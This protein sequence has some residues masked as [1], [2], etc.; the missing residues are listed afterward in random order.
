MSTVKS[1]LCTLHTDIAQ[2]GS[3]LDVQAAQ[4][5][6]FQINQ[7]FKSDITFIESELALKILFA[8]D[9]GI[10]CF[11][12]S[13]IS[14][15]PINT[16][17]ITVDILFLFQQLIESFPM[18]IVN[19]IKSI[20]NLCNLSTITYKKNADLSIR[21]YQLYEKLL[22]TKHFSDQIEINKIVEH[23]NN[24]V[25]LGDKI[26][27][28]ARQHIYNLFGVIAQHHPMYLK[29]YE[30]K[31]MN[32]FCYELQS[33]IDIRETN[34]KKFL[35]PV[36]VGCL[37]GLTGFLNNFADHIKTRDYCLRLYE[38][39]KKLIG[40]VE[41]NKRHVINRT[42]LNLFQKHIQLFLKLVFQ[43]STEVMWFQKKLW[44]WSLLPNI[45][46]K[47]IGLS[48]FEIFHKGASIEFSRQN[49]IIESNISNIQQEI[50][51]NMIMFLQ[52]KLCDIKLNYQ[53]HA[54]VVRSIGWLAE[55]CNN[56][57][58]EK[59]LVEIFNIFSLQAEEKYLNCP[60]GKKTYDPNAANYLNSLSLII[61]NIKSL[62]TDQ[63]LF[64]QKLSIYCFNDFISAQSKS[65]W[66]DNISNAIIISI[67][68][69]A[70][71]HGNILDKYLKQL[72][73][74]GLI[75]SC[76]HR[77]AIDAEIVE[78]YTGH[79]LIK[80]TN[81][82]SLW[83]S[84]L[85]AHQCHLF[86][87]YLNI[88]IIVKSTLE[89][90]LMCSF[91]SSVLKIIKKLDLSTNKSSDELEVEYIAR[92]PADI[93]ALVNLVE[94]Y[95]DILHNL[96]LDIESASSWLPYTLNVIINHSIEYPTIS[97]LYRILAVI[98]QELDWRTFLE[99]INNNSIKE[100][101][102]EYVNC[103]MVYAH[104]F[105]GDLQ[106]CCLNMFMCLPSTIV[107]EIFNTQIVEVVKSTLIVGSIFLPMAKS[108]VNALKR[109][110]QDLSKSEMDQLLKCIMPYLDLL[111]R[112][113]GYDNEVE[114]NN[115]VLDQMQV[116]DN[117]KR[118]LLKQDKL[119][120]KPETELEI[121]QIQILEYLSRLDM[122]TCLE[123]LGDPDRLINYPR[124]IINYKL[125][126]NDC[127][128]NISFDHLLPRILELC[129]YC[130]NRQIRFTAC[131]IFHAYIILYLGNN[132]TLERSKP[133][134]MEIVT[135]K[136][137]PI[138]IK[139]ACDMD[140]LIQQLFEPLAI[141][142]VHYFASGIQYNSIY[143][144]IIIDILM[145]SISENSNEAVRDF[146][147]KCIMEF[148]RWTLKDD[149]LSQQL[150]IS[151]RIIIKKIKS[152]CLHP[153]P[154]KQ[155]G[156]AVA[157]NSC[158][159]ILREDETII[160]ELWIQLLYYFIVKLDSTKSTNSEQHILK[161]L[162]HLQRVFLEKSNLFNEIC[163]SRIIPKPF[164]GTQ[165]FN[166]VEWLLRYIGS[167]MTICRS[168]CFDMANSLSKNVKD[169]N[170]LKSI[171]NSFKVSHGEKELINC[172]ERDLTSFKVLTNIDILIHWLNQ[173]IATL[174]CYTSLFKESM[175]DI[176]LLKNP[177][178]CL[179]Q[180]IHQFLFHIEELSLMQWL[181]Y[182][183]TP[184]KKNDKNI[185][186]Q[187]RYF[188]TLKNHV[189][190]G[191][192]QFINVFENNLI[193]GLLDEASQEKI[194]DLAIKYL[195]DCEMVYSD[196]KL[197]LHKLV[198]LQYIK[199]P[200][201][202]NKFNNKL[203][204]HLSKYW[205]EVDFNFN[206][207][208]EYTFK[209]NFIAVNQLI[210]EC[211]I[212]LT[213]EFEEIV[214]RKYILE[215]VF[216]Y[217]YNDGVIVNVESIR[218]SYL[219]NL[220]EFLINLDCGNDIITLL[221]MDKS[222]IIDTNKYKYELFS[223]Y[224]FSLFSKPITKYYLKNPEIFATKLLTEYPLNDQIFYVIL[225]VLK[226]SN[227][228]KKDFQ[229]KLLIEKIVNNRQ[230][231]EQFKN[232]FSWNEIFEFVELSSNVIDTFRY[233]S[234]TFFQQWICE[235]LTNNN[236][237][238]YHKCRLLGFLPKLVSN[239]HFKESLDCTI[240]KCLIDLRDKHFPGTSSKLKPHSIDLTNIVTTFQKILT[241]ME[242]S[243]SYLLF[244]IIVEWCV[245]DPNHVIIERVNNC[246]RYFFQRLS[247]ETQL[248]C[249]NFVYKMFR[250]DFISESRREMIVNIFLVPIMSFC[251]KNVIT[252]FYTD[253]IDF[254]LKTVNE[255]LLA[256]DSGK[257]RHLLISKIACFKLIEEM[258]KFFTNIELNNGCTIPYTYNGNDSKSLITQFRTSAVKVRYSNVDYTKGSNEIKQLFRQLHCYSFNTLITIISNTEDDVDKYTIFLFN[259]RPPK[260]FIWRNLVD[261]SI[262]YE[263]PIDFE[264]IPQRKKKLINIRT[265]SNQNIP[266]VYIDLSSHL[267]N[268]L[269]EDLGSYDYNNSYLR[270]DFVEDCSIPNSQSLH[271]MLSVELEMD[272][273]NNHECMAHLCAVVKYL[274]S[275]NI[276]GSTKKLN[277]DMPK[278]MNN[279]KLVFYD[280][281]TDTINS[282]ILLI[283][284]IINCETDFE[285]YAKHWLSPIMQFVL[286]KH[287]G[288]NLNYFIIDVVS[289]L[290]SW[291]NSAVPSTKN[292]KLLAKKLFSFLLSVSHSEIKN[293]FKHN[294]E[295]IKFI[296]ESW[297]CSLEMDYDE[298]LSL[299]KPNQIN[300]K[301]LECGLHLIGILS[302]NGITPFNELN[303]KNFLSLLMESLKHNNQVIYVL[304]SEIFGMLLKIYYENSINEMELLQCLS[305]VLTFT[306]S[307][308]A[309]KILSCLYY[310]HKHYSK[311]IDSYLD[312]L[313]HI[314]EKLQGVHRT[315]CLE[316]ILNRLAIINNSYEKI[317]ELNDFFNILKDNGT[318]DQLICLKII[319]QLIPTVHPENM[320]ML[321]KIIADISQ[322]HNNEHRKLIYEIMYITYDIYLGN[323][324]DTS[325][326]ITEECKIVLLNGL[327]DNDEELRHKV[328]R[329]WADDKRLP[330]KCAD[331]LLILLDQLYSPNIESHFLGNFVSI[332]LESCCTALDFDQKIFQYPLHAC[333]F[334]DYNL[335]ASWRA[336][337][338]STFP[339][340][341]DTIVSQL[342][343]SNMLG[344]FES[345]TKEK[346]LIKNTMTLQFQPT[347]I[348]SQLTDN[349][350]TLESY[351]QMSS[352]EVNISTLGVNQQS[353]TQHFDNI[354][355]SESHF[356]Q[357]K[358]V[359][360]LRNK[361]MIS[362]HFAIKSIQTNVKREIFKKERAQK[363]ESS[364]N[365][366]RKYR[367]GDFPDIEITNASVIKPLIELSKRDNNIAR[368]IS[369]SIM[370]GLKN[371]PKVNEQY[372]ESLNKSLITML[373][374][375][376]GN[377][378][379]T[380]FI[381]DTAYCYPTQINLD[382]NKV[383]EVATSCGLMSLGALV[384][385]TSI[386]NL[387]SKEVDVHIEKRSKITYKCLDDNWIKLAE[388]YKNM[389]ELDV[390]EGI[391]QEKIK[392]LSCDS[393]KEALKAEQSQ[394]W[395]M[396][397]I[398]FKS[399]LECNDENIILESD[400]D[401]LFEEYYK[402]SENLSDWKE[403]NKM[404][405]YQTG[406]SYEKIW[407][408]NWY[409]NH[410]LRRILHSELN[411]ILTGIPN[412]KF[413]KIFSNWLND[414]HKEKYI[415]TR[416]PAQACMIFLC[417]DDLNK[418]QLWCKLGMRNF[419]KE[420]ENISP[421][422]YKLRADKLLNLQTLSEIYYFIKSSSNKSNDYTKI[423]RR[424][425]QIWQSQLPIDSDSLLLWDTKILTRSIFLNKI[426]T[427]ID[428]LPSD[429]KCCLKK[430]LENYEMKSLLALIESAINKNNFYVAKK[431]MNE[432]RFENI[433]NSTSDYILCR[434]K[435]LAMSSCYTI[436]VEK[437]LKYY[438]NSWSELDNIIKEQCSQICLLKTNFHIANISKNIAHI[439]QEVPDINLL[440]KNV[441]S[442]IMSKIK[443][444]IQFDSL[445][446]VLQQIDCTIIQ[447]LKN[448]IH[449]ALNSNLC[450]KTIVDSHLMLAQYCLEELNFKGSKCS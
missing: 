161:S 368:I 26:P 158:Y 403:I 113:K 304:S 112:T 245:K 306:E 334:E 288:N 80:S 381:L 115:L 247:D 394:D 60:M 327:I 302:A 450:T 292:E 372:F 415:L 377:H 100:K 4:Q 69:L 404:L 104:T 238:I 401:F 184:L 91:M 221:I 271:Q 419:L 235:H 207:L 176:T 138:V 266:E 47:K 272:N 409:K 206:T 359:R 330:L 31:L 166:V 243:S 62:N 233:E 216:N 132:L 65:E 430:F 353:W 48:S 398:K 178:S 348:Q 127:K 155:L 378:S 397:Q 410:L 380:G 349:I 171:L 382:P 34:L 202:S 314:F 252:K 143:T 313:F 8:D 7:Y 270:S 124:N 133:T 312:D 78:K 332:L 438:L 354:L 16:K 255:N 326:Q 46:D 82:V 49:K 85:K 324:D 17:I 144:P 32:L 198:I 325:K 146:S 246:L 72:F 170:S 340:F 129:Q 89:K 183:N 241:A 273:F 188:N 10:I 199:M 187:S 341:A 84:L 352:D 28:T 74:M 226:T 142:V 175:M 405:K 68:C 261:C 131:E 212:F 344:N 51:K 370:Y 223:Q 296:V 237:N 231:C 154:N 92:K 121:V 136:I 190:V 416:I 433:E 267:K 116:Q 298:L 12:K 11:A 392:N 101:I 373:N 386:N 339:K 126:F 59:Y 318:N 75:K 351:S 333:E 320:I 83:I 41:E 402:C 350:S 29:D 289:M 25:S 366:Y 107:K 145:D 236:L 406:E 229:G 210:L 222:Y 248:I 54:V 181:T 280:N 437:K 390:V 134:E 77:A 277:V 428:D 389:G 357:K 106:Y 40:I 167:P 345:N 35:P 285:P 2:N 309:T 443:S 364:V 365:T 422:Y 219:E 316:M 388:I 13:I 9:K 211:H 407:D 22:E 268:T 114:L 203:K 291:H 346:F 259:E 3:N 162:D 427:D 442:E 299:I 399:V 293:I 301:L 56:L 234:M 152:F 61:R 228:K 95:S 209:R 43:N 111:L 439:L 50:I 23:L 421:Q 30:D 191:I 362:K 27:S 321:I 177:C 24:Q 97:S 286:D 197:N 230:F 218:L 213:L 322:Q 264:M 417:C 179:F 201:I 435:I 434:S 391:F 317:T 307:M 94:I 449:I 157:F 208:T 99:K 160:N 290:V 425:I 39:L 173:L 257:A 71:S 63:F 413:I 165:L 358:K 429:E 445:T 194:Y 311:I 193:Y 343:H 168:K 253:I 76:S 57:L 174:D 1:C 120:M 383:T 278:W 205:S 274:T 5:R 38:I 269:I 90:S 408:N 141:G 297:K 103:V 374:H 337:H 156:A 300:N 444:N 263:F 73:Y 55:P 323:N 356:I 151:L 110:Q 258:F 393:L 447:N 108:A 186:I 436:D 239:Q 130:S 295:F 420:W 200:Y 308:D 250:N 214:N 149:S 15:D 58:G 384:I 182:L 232:K 37:N 140:N 363:R 385:E 395:R 21:T 150:S 195:F 287:L 66:Q 139:L 109:W 432:F 305:S 96:E 251:R 331:R 67:Y 446:E 319:L 148:L 192:F 448:C 387:Q 185:I 249:C 172:I 426:N 336:K 86:D 137:I 338:T 102:I 367:I 169:H 53:E 282:K 18:Y 135:T 347:I 64:I 119:I 19:Y 412:D 227:N 369:S 42:G 310:I 240:R 431:Y 6:I 215:N 411:E 424:Q 423:I 79:V 225:E 342:N 45:E 418:A 376:H 128:I 281:S 36:A 256:N 254:I 125:S 20:M 180:S 123:L 117:R 260:Q 88:P 262:S 265:K 328:F 147:A 164:L 242:L 217:V 87:L 153:N 189:I 379:L 196:E 360:I 375:S 276:I 355:N 33:Q 163:T 244:E 315:Q 70:L 361:S 440:S 284:L 44:D 294:M 159:T 329:F 283:K 220:I 335:T 279:L 396:A 52:L 371:N 441:L 275:E 14:L 105:K 93:T 118:T 98:F 81:Y 224:F 414:R 303:K 400:K 122:S 204:Q